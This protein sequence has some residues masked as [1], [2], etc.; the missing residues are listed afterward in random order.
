L[1]TELYRVLKPGAAIII[2]YPEWSKC[3]NN[4]LTNKQGKRE[5][6]E[7]T[8]YGRQ[9]YP[10]D[11]HV[12][13]MDSE[14][15]K[16]FLAEQGFGV[17]QIIPEPR[18]DHNTIMHCFKGKKYINYEQLVYEDMKRVKLDQSSNKSAH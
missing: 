10:S 13:I 16:E 12:S 8:L 17:D 7:K 11:Y 14:L 18:E 1:F 9:L 4:W 2:S 5:F 6:W 3:A 15:F